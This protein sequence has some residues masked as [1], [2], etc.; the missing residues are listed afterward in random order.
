MPGRPIN[1]QQHRLYMTLRQKHPQTTAAAMAGFS[2]STGHRAEKDPR[3]PSERAR[4]RRHGGGK[5]DPLAGLWDEEIV[6]LL[7]ATPG[8]KPITVLEE[9]QRRRP[10]RDLMPARRTLERRMRLWSAVHGEEREVIFRQNHPPGRQGMSD[11]FDA[12]DLAVTIAGQPLAHL[13]YHFTLV[14]SGW[15]HGEVVLGDESFAA[16]SAGLRDTLS[17]S[18][19]A[20]RTSTAPTASPPLS[21]I[22]NVTPARTRACATRPCAPT[23]AWSRRATIVAFAIVLEPMAHNGSS[24]EC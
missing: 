11:F 10:E 20:C 23:T 1:D 2:A 17:G 8:L 7:R 9:M 14:Y 18:S 13:I 16:L 4:D 6:P 3:P 21:P 22:S 5:P 24:H 15:E 12:R 19:A